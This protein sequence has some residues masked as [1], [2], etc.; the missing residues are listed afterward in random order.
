M[1]KKSMYNNIGTIMEKKRMGW[2]L[3]QELEER[4]KNE[5]NTWLG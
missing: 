2:K 4:G 3:N 5:K 1:K